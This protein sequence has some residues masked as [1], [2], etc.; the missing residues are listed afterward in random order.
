MTLKELQNEAKKLNLAGYSV[1]KKH[2]LE[3]LIKISKQEVLEISKE[4]LTNSIE[5]NGEVLDFEDEEDWKKLREKRIGGSDVGAIIGV[6][7][8]KSIIDVYIDKVEGSSFIGNEA[9]HWGS[10]LE[11]TIKKEFAKRHNE[12]V[13]YEVPYSIVD[14][15]LIANLDGII[16]NKETGEYGVLEIKTTNEWNK[17]DWEEDTIPQSYYAQVQHYLMM[18]GYKFAYIAVLIGGQK[19]KEFF[20]ERNEDDIEIIKNK[21][22]DFYEENILKL[23]PPM[24]DGTDAYSKYLLEKSE[25]ENE[26]IVEL[27]ELIVKGEEYKELKNKIAE[28]EKELNLKEQEILITMNNNQ[29]KKARAGEYKFTIVTVN[30]KSVDKKTLEKNHSDL[31][32]QL[33]KLE[34]EYT[35]IKS[36]IYLRVS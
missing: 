29:V 6:N 26:E 27:D 24:P 1:L 30:R 34:E 28:L 19:Y 33:K 22:K 36:S 12:F 31:I 14:D 9:T 11:S 4:E 17:K 2:E 21:A 8:Y 5:I 23:I 16:K 32:N 13:V 20:I 3:E 7:P 10:M 25:K 15:F 35:T 18:T